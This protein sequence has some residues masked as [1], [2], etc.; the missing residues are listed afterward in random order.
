[1]TSNLKIHGIY[2]TILAL[3]AFLAMSTGLVLGQP[4]SPDEAAA[5]IGAA[6]TF[7]G[8]LE[9]G[10]EPLD[11]ACQMHFSLW[12][13]DV[14]GAQI[15]STQ[16]M[17]DVMVSEGLFT[18]ELN[19]EG[20]FGSTAFS[21]GSRWLEVG[22]QCAEDEA[23]PFSILRPRQPLTAVPYAHGLRPGARIHAADG[24]ALAVESA[25]QSAIALQV[26]GHSSSSNLPAL[27]SVNDVSGGYAF[28]T[29]K[30]TGSG[31]ASMSRNI[32]STGSGAAGYSQGW[33]GVYGF[34]G[35]SNHNYGFYSP[36]NLYTRNVQSAGPLMM[37]AQNLGELSLESGDVA[38]FAGVDPNVAGLDQPLI[39]VAS[40]ALGRST[41]VAG[42]VQGRFPAELLNAPPEGLNGLDL[43]GFDP[44]APIE[45]GD[46][47][48][49]VVYGVAEVKTDGLTNDLQPGDAL[50]LDRLGSGLVARAT[51]ATAAGAAFG[52]ALETVTVTDTTAQPTTY[53]FVT[54]R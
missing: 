40:A 39:Q 35:V 9:E 38:T 4:A 22:V 43:R 31:V 46:Y 54:L 19:G 5:D 2:L 41:S 45:K 18:V 1:M 37:V 12:D 20:N 47:L 29:E 48:L 10:D 24:N 33:F 44:A 50:T 23:A 3:I 53:V 52:T 34:T 14:D 49:L 11:G 30:S 27:K 25:S 13:G 17:T 51:G 42:V 6:F 16:V 15:G 8:V 28:V 7:Q 21:G 36:D 26:T 32:G